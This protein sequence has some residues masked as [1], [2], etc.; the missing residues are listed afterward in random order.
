[1]RGVSWIFHIRLGGHDRHKLAICAMAITA[2]NHGYKVEDMTFYRP[3]QTGEVPD[4]VIN[5]REK[6]RDG[7]K[8]YEQTFRY[9]VEIIDS[10]DPVPNP[11]ASLLMGFDDV[12]KVLLK[13]GDRYCYSGHAGRNPQ[14]PL[15]SHPLCVDGLLQLC[16]RSLP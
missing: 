6:M 8:K 7:P 2:S 4:L 1:M 10:N 14:A 12:V 5:R 11:K 13:G 16:E 9:R 15:A 3:G